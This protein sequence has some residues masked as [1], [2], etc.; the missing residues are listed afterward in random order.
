ME[1]YTDEEMELAREYLRG[2]YTEVQLNYLAHSCGSDRNRMESLLEKMSYQ[3]PM[4]VASKVL[5]GMMMF[6]FLACAIYAMAQ[7]IR[8]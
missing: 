5:I 8:L 6:H 2:H 4:I 3:D 1:D 7:H